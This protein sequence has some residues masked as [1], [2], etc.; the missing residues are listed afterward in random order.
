M[1][2]Q[3]DGK[4]AVITG[5]TKGIGFAAAERIDAEGAT[6]VVNG[7]SREHVDRALAKLGEKA[8][9]VAADLSTSS[10][11]EGFVKNVREIGEPDILI[12]NM[13]IFE[14]KDFF[15]I[16]DKD[17]SRFFE[18][19]VM[20][21]VRLARAFMPGMLER[22]WGRIVF[23]SSESGLNIPSEMIHY[24]MTKTAYLSISRGL[25]ELTTGTGVAANSVLP[26]PTWSEGVGG[27]VEQLAEK[28][29]M[30]TEKFVN[31][32]FFKEARPTSIIKRFA[33]PGEVANM[34]D[35]VSSPL[36]LANNGGAL[37]VDGGTVK[38][39]VP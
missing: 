36:A 19:S 9:G 13:G 10:G 30:D 15:D 33:S 25:A 31:E 14:P 5:S 20:S 17:W 32:V 28:K 34:I 6:V 12:N 29:G 11:V 16:T 8:K 4:L 23:L 39:I 27:F 18:T 35:Y 22:G 2:L 1:D 37:R 7:R 38:S 21:G 26:G 3:L 24:G